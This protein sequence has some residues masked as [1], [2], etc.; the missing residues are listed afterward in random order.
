MK[1]LKHRRKKDEY[2]N[3]IQEEECLPCIWQKQLDEQIKKCEQQLL[4]QQQPSV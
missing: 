2:E 3:E 1:C 4:L